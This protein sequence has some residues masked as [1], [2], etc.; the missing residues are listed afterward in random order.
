MVGGRRH[1]VLIVRFRRLVVCAAALG[2][3]GAGPSPP[4]E[5]RSLE[6]EAI[7][8]LRGPGDPNLVL[9]FWATW[10]REC[11]DELPDLGRAAQACDPAR[12]RVIA[13][14]I[15]EERDLVRAFLAQHAFGL[16]VLLDPGGKAWRRASLFGVPSNLVW[17][18]EGVSRSAGPT[19]AQAWRE[20]LEA[21]GCRTATAGASPPAQP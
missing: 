2:L 18:E 19:S 17:T 13:V 15:G 6:G 8:I 3:L 4:I 10:C 7:Q 21:L 1:G 12:V 11:A 20:K 5:L 9:H 14:N 16:P